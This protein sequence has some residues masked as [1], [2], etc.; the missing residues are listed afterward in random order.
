MVGYVCFAVLVCHFASPNNSSPTQGL[1]DASFAILTTS[2]EKNANINRKLTGEKRRCGTRVRP[3]DSSI[4]KS[5]RER[6]PSK[7]I[8]YTLDRERLGGF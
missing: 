8:S 4:R 1:I 5:R 7:I 3:E 2:S 6:P